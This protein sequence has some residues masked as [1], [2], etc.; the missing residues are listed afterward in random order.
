MTKVED[1]DEDIQQRGAA[2]RVGRMRHEL[3]WSVLIATVIEHVI[4]S[5]L[6]MGQARGLNLLL[7]VLLAVAVHY[8]MKRDVLRADL[9]SFSWRT[10]SPWRLIYWPLA[11]ALIIVLQFRFL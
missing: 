3:G 8:G 4:R 5:G 7:F 1:A 9:T 2:A 11:T 6:S 10:R